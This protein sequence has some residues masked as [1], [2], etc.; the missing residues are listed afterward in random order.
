MKSPFLSLVL[1]VAAIAVN[2]SVPD[3]YPAPSQAKS[4]MSAA[5]SAAAATQKRVIVDFGGNWCPDCHALDLYFHDAANQ[6][7]IEANFILVHVNIGRLDENLDI[8]ERYAIPL[9]KGVP[10]LAIL[11]EKGHLLFG[12]K[13]GEFEAMRHMQSASV[14]EFLLRWQRRPVDRRSALPGQ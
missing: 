8:A 5:L 2:A 9:R 10:A 4:D 11:D 14:T 1:A 7:I 6:P 13:N 3:I 12:Q